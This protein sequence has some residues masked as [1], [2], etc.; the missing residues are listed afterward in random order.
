MQLESNILIDKMK[1]TSRISVA[2]I[3]VFLLHFA[4]SAASSFE[5]IKRMAELG[6]TVA[7]LNLGNSYYV[8]NGTPQNYNEAAKWYLVAAKKGN[9]IAQN[10]LGMMYS[11]GI[12]VPKILIKAYVWSSVA[13]AKGNDQAKKNRDTLARELTRLQLARAQKIAQRCFDSDFKDCGR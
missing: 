9:A 6:D 3:S 8:G 5:E 11:V 4:S 10:N 12:G 2:L 7:Q 1:R 13:A